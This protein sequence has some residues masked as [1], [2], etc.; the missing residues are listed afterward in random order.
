MIPA[1]SL[2]SLAMSVVGGVVLL[3]IALSL[4]SLLFWLGRWWRWAEQRT[5]AYQSFE[6]PRYGE[7][8]QENPLYRRVATYVAALPTLE[9]SAAVTLFSSGRKPNDFFLLLG[10]GHSAVDSFLGARVAWT[11]A[12]AAASGG[13]PRFVLRLRRQDRTRVLRPYLQHVESVADDLELRRRDVRL[14]ICSGGNP[15]WRSLPFTHPATIDT[16][17]MDEDLKMR[18][19]ADM[20]SF[21]KGRDYYHRLGRVWRRSYLLY[22]PPGTGKSTFVA[23]MAKFLCYD[24]YDVDLSHV[25]AAGDADGA[26]LKGLL[27]STTPRSIILVEDLDRHLKGK[28]VGEEGES[29]QLTRIL[30]FMDGIFS[31]CGEER[32]MV[33]TMNSDAGGMEPAVL[34]PGRLDVHIHFPLCDFA[35]FKTLASSY[36]GLKDHKLYQQ[37]EEVFQ[38]G[39]RISPAEV[40]EIMIANRASPSRALKSVINTLQQQTASAV[41]RTSSAG[42]RLSESGSGRR[43]EDSATAGGDPSNV[44]VGGAAMGFGKESIKEFKKLYGMIKLR[45]GSKKDGATTLELA[46]AAAGADAGAPPVKVDKDY[47][48]N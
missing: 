33:F 4:K 21:L 16:M 43:C 30:N 40:G 18:V 35:A 14:H 12:P 19:R 1:V 10:P 39:V 27:L 23:A 48:P 3:R 36:L 31:C 6:I 9:D 41:V 2:T 17:A 42:R 25:S 32:V 11:N 15:R 7:K 38:S 44:G 45:S 37:V 47:I 24:I 34:R 29:L 22:G 20:E 8:G 13:A 5:Q 28:G 26:D 46:A